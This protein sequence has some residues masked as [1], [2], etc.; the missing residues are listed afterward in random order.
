M[1][2]FQQTA[3]WLLAGSKGGANRIKILQ[4]LE[5]KPLNPN[6][7]SKKT[8][9]NYKTV[10]HHIGL[11]TQNQL[12]VKRGNRYGGVFFWSEELKKN[13]GLFKKLFEEQI[14]GEEK[15]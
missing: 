10:Q 9:L 13:H 14:Q 11:L 12:L 4:E 8:G 5:K 7:L 6:E 1:D 2:F 15:K 3:Y